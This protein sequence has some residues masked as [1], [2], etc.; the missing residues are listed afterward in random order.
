MENSMD[1]KYVLFCA[2][3]DS[4]DVIGEA[5]VQ[6]VIRKGFTAKGLG[7]GRMQ[8]AGL[9][10]IADYEELPVSGFGDVIPKYFRLRKIF[11]KLQ[12]ALNDE[13]CIAY[14]AIDYPGF[15]MKLTPTTKKPVLYVAPPQAWAWKE[16]RAA[17][18]KN[19]PL[20]VLFDFEKKFYEAK[21]CKASVLKH[22]FVKAA[23][24]RNNE[25]QPRHLLLMPGSRK[26]QALR[27][28]PFYM[29]VASEWNEKAG[30][31]VVILAA[32]DSLSAAIEGGVR[33]A[34]NG[35]LPSWISIKTAPEDVSARRI[36]LKSYAA[37]LATPGSATLE[38]ALAGTPLIIAM[39]P[40]S[41]TY[42]LGK[43]LIRTKY[44]G[45][46]NILLNREIAPEFIFPKS[47]ANQ[48]EKI[49]GVATALLNCKDSVSAAAASAATAAA[50]ELNEKLSGG[51]SPEELVAEL[52]G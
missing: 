43:R 41:L 3:E 50:A 36:M 37:A 17:K 1:Q 48:S 31:N 34:F 33:K 25:V 47:K 40:D 10:L 45:L 27:N 6:A 22:P 19:V 7:G 9:Q 29:K 18:L 21:G 51:K 32:R 28:I 38:V 5:F 42:Q 11:Q 24:I 15:N 30:E 14:V 20:A 2:G 4:G 49:S 16:H 52:L 39:V 44:F 23:E 13:N 46:P 8:K 12:M 35:N 26:S